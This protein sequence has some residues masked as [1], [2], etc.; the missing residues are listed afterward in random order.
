MLIFYV[1]FLL[2]AIFGLFLFGG[3]QVICVLL[4]A[5]ALVGGV[6]RIVGRGKLRTASLCLIPVCLILCLFTGQTVEG[7]LKD[8][9]RQMRE[10]A[11]Q[12]DKGKLDDG[13]EF[14]DDLDE[15]YGVTDLSRYAR[16]D[17]CLTLGE[18]STALSLLNDVDDKS[19][20]NWYEYMERF[21]SEQETDSDL[22][23]LRELYL[24]A[25]EELP[26]NSRMQYMAGLAELSGGSY[27]GASYYFR[28]ARE[29]DEKDASSCY[30]LGLICYEQGRKEEAAAYF[31]EALQRGADEEKAANI[32][33]YME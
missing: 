3:S 33:W 21:Y 14:L 15:E 12:I 32:Q 16:A 18:Y 9:G 5:A 20:V 31:E 27:Q 2:I 1:S 10:I 28:R 19:S 7:G 11:A 17:I 25:A 23:R 24:S 4:T 8:Y 26:G 6:L 29:L 13:L 30:Y 22:S